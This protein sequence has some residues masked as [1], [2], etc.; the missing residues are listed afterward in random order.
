M[1]Y[2]LFFGIIPNYKVLKILPGRQGRDTGSGQA[3]PEGELRG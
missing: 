2:F 3:L 1:D